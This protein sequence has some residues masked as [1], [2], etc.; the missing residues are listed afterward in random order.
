MDEPAESI[1]QALGKPCNKPEIKAL[2]KFLGQR[3]PDDYQTYLMR[4]GSGRKRDNAPLGPKEHRSKSTRLYLRN[5]S[6]LFDQF[7]P[8]NPIAAGAI[9]FE[10]DDGRRSVFFVPR[11]Q[12]GFD[13]VDYDMTEEINRHHSLAQYFRHATALSGKIIADHVRRKRSKGIAT[14]RQAIDAVLSSSKQKP[15]SMTAFKQTALRLRGQ[16]P[17]GGVPNAAIVKELATTQ[18]AERIVRRL[19]ETP[20]LLAAAGMSIVDGAT[21][22]LAD[23][24]LQPIAPGVARATVRR[25]AQ[26]SV[27]KAQ[28][29]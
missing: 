28:G 2:E 27:D 7:A 22:T 15:L 24:A 19:R 10:L 26:K 12:G 14:Q 1:E 23:K 8:S 16:L 21:Q 9:P 4:F 29:E 11:K 17:D 13:I 20:T 6:D 3:L 18:Q 25:C 5:K